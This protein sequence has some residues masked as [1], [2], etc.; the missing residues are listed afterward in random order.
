MP[1]E[2]ANVERRRAPRLS[3]RIPVKYRL[4]RNEKVLQ[5]IEDWRLTENNALTLDMSLGGM[6]IAVDQSLKVGDVLRFDIHL[7]NKTKNADVYAKVIRTN[8]KS[9]G[10]Q[11][12]MMNDEEREALKAFF[13][14][15][16]F[17]QSRL[18]KD[19]PKKI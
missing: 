2:K 9:V 10:L 17:N 8:K 11:F 16:R 5:S 15:L 14:F 18:Q 7:L 3:M 1:K 13:E 4:E 19:A 12:L 6:Q